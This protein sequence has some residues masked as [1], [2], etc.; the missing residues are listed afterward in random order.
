MVIQDMNRIQKLVDYT[1]SKK[2]YQLRDEK[3]FY[4]DPIEDINKF[5]NN[6]SSVAGVGLA[7]DFLSSW[8]HYSYIFSFVSK[9]VGNIVTEKQPLSM[10]TYIAIEANNLYFFLGKKVEKYR[11]SIP[12][13]KSIKH[14]A[15]AL[16]LGWDDLGINYGNLLLHM[17]YGKQYQGWHPAYLHP[18]FML[19]I[20]CKWQKI[21]LDYSQL[22]YPEEMGIYGS[23]LK[24]WDTEDVGLLSQLVDNLCEYHIAESDEDEYEDRTPD[25]P[26]SDYFLYAIEILLWLNIRERMGLP[27][28]TPGNELMK[29]PINN[30]HTQKTSVPHIA[31]IEKVKEKLLEDYPGI[32]FEL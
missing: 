2:E 3:Y 14:M 17:L 13:H 9:H 10:S 24:S 16:L 31:L 32:D 7:F 21:E 18:W 6:D 5:I 22:N 28:Y 1:Q 8:Y 19:E 25:F 15:Q 12:F 26:S 29:L 4:L 27:G 20:F 11:R 23:V 30:W